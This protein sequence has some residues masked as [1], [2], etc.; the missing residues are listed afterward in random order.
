MRIGILGALQTAFRDDGWPLCPHCG[1]DEL[2]S[3]LQW[4]GK[5]AR[6]PIQDYIDAG[7]SCY[8][9]GPVLPRKQDALRHDPATD[10]AA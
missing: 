10:R 9:C 8:R 2:W 4:D 5:G 6:P 1:D 3:R 7:L